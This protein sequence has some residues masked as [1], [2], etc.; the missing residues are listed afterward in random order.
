MNLVIESFDQVVIELS[1]YL[2]IAWRFTREAMT[3]ASLNH[4]NIA[5]LYGLES[6]AGQA[7]LAATRR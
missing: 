6:Q 3:L 4:P 2:V 5:H 7:G 1:G